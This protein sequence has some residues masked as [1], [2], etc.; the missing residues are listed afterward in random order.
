M[1]MYDFFLLI[2]HLDNHCNESQLDAL[3]IPNLF[4]QS[5]SASFGHIC[6]PSSG[7]LHRKCTAVGTC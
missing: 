6:C 1:A 2:V 3:F 7:G 4:N 5:I